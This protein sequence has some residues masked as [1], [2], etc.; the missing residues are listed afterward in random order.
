MKDKKLDDFIVYLQKN[1]YT[2]ATVDNYYRGLKNFLNY[3]QTNNIAFEGFSYQNIKNYKELLFGQGKSPQSI[4]SVLFAIKKYASYI[5]APQLI[6]LNYSAD[7][8]RVQKKKKLNIISNIDTLIQH[9][10]EINKNEITAFRDKLIIE[11]LYYAGI[12]AQELIKIKKQDIINN[13]LKIKGKNIILN[14]LLIEDLNNYLRL[15]EI[16]DDGYLF[17]AYSRNN[18]LNKHHHLTTRSIENIF[19]RYKNVINLNLS[20]GDLRNAYLVNLKNQQLNINFNKIFNHVVI[21][22]NADYL[23]VK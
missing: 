20:I 6:D 18:T 8:M 2:Q 11:I 16:K 9:I 17:F 12:R 1:A 4:N 7:I 14:S 13:I 15:I 5:K 19:N 10:K 21:T 22:T 3:L 23:K